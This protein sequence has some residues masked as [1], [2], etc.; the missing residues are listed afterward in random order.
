MTS[1]STGVCLEQEFSD[2]AATLTNDINNL[3]TGDMTSL[4]DALYTAVERVAAQNG[5]RCVIAF[6]DGNDNYSNCTKEDVVNV[7]NRY[8]VPVFIIGIGSIDYADVNDIATQTGGMYYNGSIWWNLKIIQ[9]Q[10]SGI[11]QIFKPDTTV[12]IM[13]ENVNTHTL[14]TFL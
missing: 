10:L 6:T 13:A 5:A 14:R 4:Y 9:V 11:P 8:H 2:D 1:F 3:V 12:S 7:A